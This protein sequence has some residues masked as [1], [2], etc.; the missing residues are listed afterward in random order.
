MLD[1]QCYLLPQ[2][3]S[4]T[5]RVCL[6]SQKS[7]VQLPASTVLYSGYEVILIHYEIITTV[8]GLE[9]VWL[10]D[11]YL[12]QLVKEFIRSAKS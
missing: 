2:Q 8:Y 10:R 12:P 4:D 9:T 6:V 7:A 3:P 5:Y 1:P 11:G